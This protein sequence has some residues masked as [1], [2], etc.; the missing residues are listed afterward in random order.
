[1]EKLAE[2]GQKLHISA[3]MNGMCCLAKGCGTD[4]CDCGDSKE[5]RAAEDGDGVKRQVGP[6]GSS[7]SGRS[8]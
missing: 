4:V 2:S 5:E 1:M 3:L 6:C 7:N 8:S